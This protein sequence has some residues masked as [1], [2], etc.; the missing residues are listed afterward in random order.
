MKTLRRVRTLL[1]VL[2]SLFLFNA[3]CFADNAYRPGI[4]IGTAWC[5]VDDPDGLAKMFIDKYGHQSYYLKL[6]Y[7]THP[8]GKYD[9]YNEILNYPVFGVGLSYDNYS[10]LGFKNNSRLGDFVNVFGFME[11]PLYR[12]RIVSLGY[13]LAFGLGA[14]GEYYDPYRNPNNYLVGA[15]LA[16]YM[17]FGPQI[18]LR[19]SEHVE[20]ILNGS[21]FHHSTGNMSQPNYGLNDF[22]AGVDLRYNID[23]PYTQ[24]VRRLSLP[25]SFPKGFK[26]DVFGTFGLHA[27][28]TE[29]KAYNMMVEDPDRKQAVLPA[30]PRV[31]VAMDAVYRYCQLCSIG[32]TMDFGY[33]WDSAMLR[34]SDTVIYGSK[35]VKEGPGYSPFNWA[36][37][38]IHEFHYGNFAAF[39]G[40]SRYLF[41]K[42]GI[43][44]N[45]ARFFQRA[46]MRFYFPRLSNTFLGMCIR[47]TKFNNA[48]FF[49]FQM[50]IR[51]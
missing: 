14:T 26:F 44:E 5:K 42:V 22:M 34:S 40:C 12:N 10:S 2:I 18:K 37:G 25:H 47:A 35:A 48:D 27:C 32:L 51:I 1:S 13:N 23:A 38:F 36:L 19:P 45:Q 4:S 49:E 24:Q 50:G 31:G 11:G 6:A 29:L 16:V 28:K 33:H 9:V 20:V 21:W 3:E 46:G 7:S 43:H 41:R 17:T 39:C 15:P 30:R 8:G